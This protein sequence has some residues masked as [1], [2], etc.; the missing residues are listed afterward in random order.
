MDSAPSRCRQTP[1]F[2][3]GLSHA[4]DRNSARARLRAQPGGCFGDDRSVVLSL[5]GGLIGAVS[6]GCLRRYQTHH[7]WQSFSRWRLPLRLLRTC[8][9]VACST[10]S[11]GGGGGLFPALRAARMPVVTAP[12][13]SELPGGRRFTTTGDTPTYKFPGSVHQPGNGAELSAGI[14]PRWHHLGPTPPRTFRI[15]ETGH[16][17][18]RIQPHG[19]VRLAELRGRSSRCVR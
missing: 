18:L 12:G 10:P 13:S 9:P 2:G 7:D 4:R 16:L 15:R 8:W 14:I 11:H 3:G 17:L 1:V 6:P 5:V 19:T